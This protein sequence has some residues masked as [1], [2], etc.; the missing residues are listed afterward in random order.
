MRNG[1]K[2]PQKIADFLGFPASVHIDE[3]VLRSEDVPSGLPA[4]FRLVARDRAGVA[5]ISPFLA[6][7]AQ[8]NS[9]DECSV[10]VIRNAVASSGGTSGTPATSLLV[11]NAEVVTQESSPDNIRIFTVSSVLADPCE[12]ADI[13]DNTSDNKVTFNISADIS[14]TSE[15]SGSI[16]LSPGT[17]SSTFSGSAT[18]EDSVLTGLSL[19]GSTVIDGASATVNISCSQD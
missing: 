17:T 8:D 5:T 7:A 15:V 2:I 13:C 10:Q 3:N 18:V 14:N 6:V 4:A 12:I 19:N 9:I 16:S 11:S 1:E